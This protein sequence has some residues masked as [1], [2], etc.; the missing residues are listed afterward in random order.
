MGSWREVFP[1]S[2]GLL[3]GRL[4]F[5]ILPRV[6]GWEKHLGEVLKLTLKNLPKEWEFFQ[7]AWEGDLGGALKAL[8]YIQ[9]E[10]TREF[11]RWVLTGSCNSELV[12]DGSLRALVEGKGSLPSEGREDLEALSNLIEARSKAVMNRSEAIK[13]LDRAILKVS[14]ISPV[15][16]ANLMLMKAKLLQE[17]GVSY[18]L[19]Q[20]YMEIR[21]L[22]KDT[23]ARHIVGEANFQIGSIL[24]S[25]G[26]V[27]EAVKYFR[28]ALDF[29]TKEREPYTWAL[30]N[31]NLGLALLAEPAITEE[32]QMRLAMGIQHLKKALEV[33]TREDYPQEWASTTLNYANALVYAP[34]AEPVKNLLRAV[35]LYREVLSFR[36]KH[37]PEES[38]A[39]VLANLGNALA[40]L[41]KREEAKE[42]LLRARNLFISLNMHEEAEAVRELIEEIEGGVPS[43]T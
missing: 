23:G 34:T 5:L 24:H 33:F 20:L 26:Q 27:G 9:D 38:L 31:N 19:L 7:R 39:R 14:G 2:V 29:Y 3:P 13:A 10:E 22:V 28:E 32:D 15:F 6:E 41:G 36:E 17:R 16:Q 4:S 11:N 1:Q 37:G 30:I 8:E 43:G 42:Y 12:K 21:K 40:H 25:F 35:E 18:P